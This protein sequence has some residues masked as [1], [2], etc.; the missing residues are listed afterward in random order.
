MVIVFVF[1]EVIFL[2]TWMHPSANIIDR[3]ELQTG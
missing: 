2:V 1:Y 3:A